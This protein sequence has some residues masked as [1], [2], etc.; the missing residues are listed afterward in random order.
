MAPITRVILRFER[1]HGTDAALVSRQ[2][3]SFLSALC[4]T[5]TLLGHL[6]PGWAVLTPSSRRL[7]MVRIPA[8]TTVLMLALTALGAPLLLARAQAL[9]SKTLTGA[10]PLVIGHRG[11]SGYLPEHTI[12]AY[13]LAIEQGADFIEPDLV[14]TQDGVL[15]TRHEPML[16]GTTDVA[17]RPE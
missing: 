17:D 1:H 4:A 14:A 16:S 9:Q 3:S 12:E 15:I 7:A 13:K 5:V 8:L 2:L 11:A 10:P 6:V